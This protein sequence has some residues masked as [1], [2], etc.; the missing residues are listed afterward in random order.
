MCEGSFFKTRNLIRTWFSRVSLANPLTTNVPI[1]QKPV[2]W[3]AEQVLLVF[4]HFYQLISS[5]SYQLKLFRICNHLWTFSTHFCLFTNRSCSFL[6][7]YRSFLR[8]SF[9]VYHSLLHVYK[10]FVLVSTHL[11]VASTLLPL[12]TI[13]NFEEINVFN[14][15][16]M[17]FAN[18]FL[19]AIGWS[20]MSFVS[21]QNMKE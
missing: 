13:C 15:V 5:L 12:V 20:F 4:L 6:F 11:P 14:N 7:V 19:T 2:S 16:T 10:W 3:F 21:T 8:V 1:I 9:T 17:L 18:M